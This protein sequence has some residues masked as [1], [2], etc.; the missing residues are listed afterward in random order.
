[1]NSKHLK[2][3]STS[4]ITKTQRKIVNDTSFCLMSLRLGKI[5]EY[6][7]I[8]GCKKKKKSKVV[9][10]R[11]QAPSLNMGVK[12]QSVEDNLAITGCL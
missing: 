7:N 2:I 1:M 4:P 5:N 10:M 3:W 8:Q 12:I 6:K 11:K 9:N